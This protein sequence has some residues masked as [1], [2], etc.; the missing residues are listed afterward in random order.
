M[1]RAPASK[2]L[3]PFARSLPMALLRA[4]ESVMRGFRA[5]IREHGLSEQQWRVIRA[6][7]E[8]ERL[9]IGELAERTYIL[10]P[11][12]TR[13]LRDMGARGIVS[14]AAVAGDQRKAH[15]ALTAKGRALFDRIAPD[16]ENEYRRIEKLIGAAETAELYRL[17]NRLGAA[18]D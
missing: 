11:S 18:L 2:D 4:R 12:L 16:S 14:R 8:A 3:R 6:L 5:V 1:A 9:E 17:L 15:V 10:K 13:I 7:R